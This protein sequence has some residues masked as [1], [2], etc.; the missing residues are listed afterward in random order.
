[1]K[2]VTLI[3]TDSLGVGALPDAAAYGDAGADTFGH[4]VD[5]M[6]EQEGGINIPNLQKLGFC[7][8]DGA[9]GGRLAVGNPTGACGRFAELS[10][11]NL[12]FL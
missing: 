8:I 6:N 11:G 2:R 5:V 7:N 3:V 10:K 12:L 1:M 4:I 9:A